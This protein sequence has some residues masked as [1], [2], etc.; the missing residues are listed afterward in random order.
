VLWAISAEQNSAFPHLIHN[1]SSLSAVAHQFDTDKQSRASHV[2][3][4]LVTLL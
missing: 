2:A 1:P 3:D 4:H